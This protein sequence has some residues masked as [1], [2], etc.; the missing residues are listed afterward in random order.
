MHHIISFIAIAII[1]ILPSCGGR[2]NVSATLDSAETLMETAPD[3]A[4]FLLEQLDTDSLTGK[5][6]RALYAML[7]TEALDKNQMKP[8]DDS[9][10]SI[11]SD[12][13]DR[14][15]DNL[16]QVISNYYHGRVHF[17]NGNYNKALVTFFKSKRLAEESD[18]PFWAGMSCRGISDIYNESFNSAEEVKFALME[19][20]YIRQS[21]KQPY[22]N[23]ALSDLAGAYINS[24][25][26]DKASPIIDQM[27]DSAMEWEDANLY[28]MAQKQRVLIHLVLNEHSQALPIASDICASDY[29]ETSDSLHLSLALAET[30]R[31]DEAIGMLDSISDKKSQLV[32]VVKGLACKKD[33]DYEGVISKREYLDSITTEEIKRQFNRNLTGSLVD[34]FELNSKLEEQSRNI[35]LWRSVA[36]IFIL[37]LVLAILWLFL[38][39]ERVSRLLISKEKEMAELH[40]KKLQLE[41][42]RLRLDKEHLSLTNENLLLEKKNLLL[43]KERD[44]LEAENLRHRISELEE[45][46][47]QLSHLLETRIDMSH[48]V[49]DAIKLRLGMLNSLLAE[50]IKMHGQKRKPYDEWVGDIATDAAAFMDSTRLALSASHPGLIH[51]FEECGLTVDEI[52]YLSLYAIGLRGKEVGIYINRRSHTNL[53]SAI[54]KKL[55]IDKHETN[56]GIYVRKLMKN[57]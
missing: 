39:K 10:I 56:I 54:R 5:S 43:E 42:E 45:E 55:G 20:D 33:H 24:R 37:V 8:T 23:Y 52:N 15:S 34:Y 12:Y 14:S 27:V 26:F 4:L 6:D 2:S 17:H 3:S 29:A 11:A 44:D 22:L 35:L 19:Y 32:Y 28:Y 1:L 9:L 18:L 40:S 30:G 16:R 49:R 51:Y 46:T 50:Q 21:G 57:Y 36:V 53:S 41:S 25:E 13:Y 48:E 7:L 31:I 38:K 47:A